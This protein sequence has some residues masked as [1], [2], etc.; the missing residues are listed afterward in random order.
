MRKAI[1]LYLR[2]IK[3]KSKPL[4]YDYIQ[5]ERE[6]PNRPIDDYEIAN[7]SYNQLTSTQIAICLYIAG[8]YII[9]FCTRLSYDYEWS[10]FYHV[11]FPASMEYFDRLSVYYFKKKEEFIISLPSSVQEYYD[12]KIPKKLDT[13]IKPSELESKLA[14]GVEAETKISEEIG[15]LFDNNS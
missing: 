13:K 2:G 11:N 12:S 7:E 5:T 8:G 15:K 14:K 1:Q 4:I 3:P 9:Y 6:N 10:R